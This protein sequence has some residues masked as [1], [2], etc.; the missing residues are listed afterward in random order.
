MFVN[1]L[2]DGQNIDALNLAYGGNGL[3]LSL[4][5]YQEYAKNIKNAKILLCFYEGND[6]YET[7]CKT[8]KIPYLI[9]NTFDITNFGFK[10]K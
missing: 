3:L 2:N 7:I 5:T 9:V 6:F 8:L 10:Y 1:L 4:A